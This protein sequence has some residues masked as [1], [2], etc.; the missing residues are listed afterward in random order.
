FEIEHRLIRKD[1]EIRWVRNRHVPRRDPA[2]RIVSYDGLMSDITEKKRAS[3]ELLAA[4]ARLTKV[5][6][7]LTKTHED[8]KAA[9]SQLIQLEK[10]HSIGQ[11]AAGIAHEV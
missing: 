2:G 5:F 1:G 3:D 11:M 6:A 10:L 4:N 9:Q 8:L 7:D